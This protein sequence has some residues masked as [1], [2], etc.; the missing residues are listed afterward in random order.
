MFVV[1]S[2]GIFVAALDLNATN[3][4]FPA[5]ARTFPHSSSALS[6]ILNGNSIAYGALLITAGRL[7]DR[8][9]RR[10]VFFGGLAIFAAGSAVS[11][12][13]PSLEWLIAGRVVQGVGSSAMIPS[14]LGL[15]LAAAPADRRAVWVAMWGAVTMMAAALGP[16]L[17][18]VVIQE[19][20]WRWEFLLNLPLVAVALV[21]GR[22]VLTES[23][24]AT[25]DAPDVASVGLLS[26]ALGLLALAIVEA[27]R[28][29][30]VDSR[31][32][33]AASLS[34]IAFAWFLYRSWHTP[35]PVVDLRL[36]RDREFATANLGTVFMAGAMFTLL[37]CQV[38]FLTGTWHYGLI[39]AGFAVSPTPLAS[40]VVSW[41]AGRLAQ[42]YGFRPV[43]VVGSTV[44][45]AG[46][47]MMAFALDASPDWWT[48]W[49]PGALLVGVGIGA[50][51]P[52]FSAAAVS[53][54]PSSQFSVGS[55]V[56][57]TARQLGAILG[58]SIFVAFMGPQPDLAHFR[59]AYMLFAAW[60]L[61]AAIV[62]AVG[63]R[64]HAPAHSVEATAEAEPVETAA[65]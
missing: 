29:G 34:T 13:S 18:G 59:D 27:P 1:A 4:A 57:Q 44:F 5:I 7:A 36:F 26:G 62:V 37:F 25:S 17:G 30:W 61:T 28:W 16:T 56:N 38:L 54:L 21:W 48:R 2:L 46:A 60:S 45:A 23:A 47:M 35:N 53:A 41:R 50:T 49:L 3:L 6:W 42:R 43:L 63:L 15:L 55:A 9:G 10:R 52:I 31:T 22:A 39:Q 20:G 51:I 24:N 11:G 19:A 14:S 8:L 64:A 65:A 12:L 32:A 40:M 58:V 33:A